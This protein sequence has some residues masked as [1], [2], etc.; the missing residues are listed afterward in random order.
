MT[1]N[2]NFQKELNEYKKLFYNT[3]HKKVYPIL[4]TC[5][6]ERK[7]ILSTLMILEVFLSCVAG[8]LLYYYV[9][10]KDSKVSDP[11]GV[12]MVAVP[13]IITIL[14][15]IPIIFNANFVKKVKTKC[16]SPL[17]KIFGDNISWNKDSYE[18]I[19]DYELEESELFSA[20]NRRY[21]D[22]QFT[23]QYKNVETD[24]SETH[25]QYE[26]GS[27]KNRHVHTVF[28]GVIVKFKSNK[29]VKSKT[30][31]ADKNSLCNRSGAGL[32]FL[33][34]YGFALI[35]II[36][37]FVLNSSSIDISEILIILAHLAGFIIFAVLCVFFGR[38]KL[39]TLK[40]ED[41]NFD[42][43]FVVQSADEVEGRYLVTPSF[44]E[45]FLNLKTAFKGNNASCSFYNDNIMFAISTNK[46]LFE[47]GNLFHRLDDPKQAQI[48]FNEISSILML[49]DY[50]KLNEKTGI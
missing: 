2:N 19:P 21:N 5:E 20:Y 8:T 25:L 16:L 30:I 12:C 13:I 24:I 42:K 15:I 49:V 26:S 31:V 37:M 1:I 40:L 39:K 32:R 11:I 45:R 10:S 7:S 46:N 27:G 29:T 50:F 22:D 41:V 4:L 48:F 14:A 6:N 23:G 38:R 18:T 47:I 43:R 34:I 17:L 28:K 3:Y 33:V 9:F 36:S 44:M 35:A